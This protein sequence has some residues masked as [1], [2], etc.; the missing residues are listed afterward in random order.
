MLKRHRVTVGS[1][2]L[3]FFNMKLILSARGHIKMTP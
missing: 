2:A 1:I 3:V